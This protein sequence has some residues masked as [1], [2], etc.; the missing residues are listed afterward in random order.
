MVGWGLEAALTAESQQAEQQEFLSTEAAGGLVVLCAAVI[1]LVWANSPLSSSYDAL[2]ETEIA[3]DIGGIGL[4]EDLRHWVND[5]L[6]AFFFFVVG[7]EVKREFVHGSLRDPRAAALPI[8][9]ALGGMIVP[10]VLYLLIAGGGQPGRGWGIPMATDIAF[11][12]GVLALLGSRVPASLKA[13]LLTLAVVDDIGAIT[14][15]ALFYSQDLVAAWLGVAVAVILGI[16]V[17]QRLG[18]RALPAY[19][20]GAAVLWLAVYSSGVHATIAGV[21][22]GLLTPAWPFQPPEA[23]ASES[24]SPLERLLSALHPWT[25]FLV[26]PL[27][28]L[29]NAGVQ[30]DAGALAAVFGQP[31]TLAVI[32]GLVVGKPLGIL[33]AAALVHATTAASL[34][35]EAGWRDLAGTGLLAGI[36]FTVSLF[37]ADLAFVDDELQA[38]ARLGILLASVLA[39]AVGAAV[40]TLGRRR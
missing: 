24:V 18:I 13:F 2:W 1:A 3:L 11:A 17:A 28:A 39:G 5:L 22:L 40:L 16:L 31:V 32:V 38:S 19:A 30:L 4:A 20:V 37:I 34:P 35:E 26:L 15:I 6:M 25:S 12:L 36:G 14:V 7:L 27:F 23:V 33:G 21:A 9:C 10:A 8:I 29:A